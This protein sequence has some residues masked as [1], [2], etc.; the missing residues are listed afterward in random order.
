MNSAHPIRRA[1]HALLPAKAPQRRSLVVQHLGFEAPDLDTLPAVLDEVGRELGMELRLDGVGG[2]VVLAERD[3]VERVAPQVLHAFLEERPLLTVARGAGDRAGALRRA[4][5]LHADLV[6]QLQMLA[7]LQGARP[8]TAAAGESTRPDSGFDSDFDSR[9]P[10]PQLT[11]HELDPDRAELLNRLRRGL[12]DPGQAP[13][14]AG[15]G[16]GAA[17]RIDFAGGQVLIDELAD[18]RLRIARELPSLSRG[19]L[20]DA[21]AKV[22]DLDLVVW[23]IAYAAGGFRLLHAPVNWW[24][25]PLVVLPRVQAARYTAM[26]QHLRMARELERGPVSPA[27]LRRRCRA[28]LPDLRGFL[29]A[30][31]FLGLVHWLPEGGAAGEPA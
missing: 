5:V 11:G 3:F 12:V 18:Q 28:S 17:L 24:R 4:Q 22:R 31:L 23:D 25:T 27:D 6:R 14:L 19:P 21:R 8:V 2:D 10:T 13:L 26:P 7:E 15:Y 16:R 30:S 20:P 29:Q 9:V 1:L